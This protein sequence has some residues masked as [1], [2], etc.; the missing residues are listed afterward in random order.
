MQLTKELENALSE[1]ESISNISARKIS[2]LNNRC[3][4]LENKIRDL[5]S[6]L[7]AS[8]KTEKLVKDDREQVKMQYNNLFQEMNKIRKEA[9]ESFDE[10][11]KEYE[12]RIEQLDCE[13]IDLQRQIDKF[14]RK[15]IPKYQ[16][17]INDLKVERE[18]LYH[19]V[20]ALGALEQHLTENT[21]VLAEKDI[22]LNQI[23]EKYKELKHQSHSVTKES[24]RYM[25]IL[26][27]V[28]GTVFNIEDPTIYTYDALI[29]EMS[30][31]YT[32]QMEEI[33][34][35]TEEIKWLKESFENLRENNNQIIMETSQIAERNVLIILFYYY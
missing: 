10:R 5:E 29:K 33:K 18:Q 4:Q 32:T 2:D 16:A 20:E 13:K 17:E 34:Q 6:E 25:D 3:Y 22:V 1:K 23:K 30:S 31:K 12:K 21:R 14:N 35:L 9:N 28:A 26:M 24:D 19:D 15:I 8:K 11:V 7:K 27:S